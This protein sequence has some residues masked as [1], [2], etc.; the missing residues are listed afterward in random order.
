MTIDEVFREL[1]LSESAEGL[2][3]GWDL[4]QGCFPGLP[5][6]FLDE[7]YIRENAALVSLDARAID[8]LCQVAGQYARNEAM[9]RLLWHEHRVYT[10]SGD[11]GAPPAPPRRRR[12]RGGRDFVA[13]LDEEYQASGF[14]DLD[15]TIGDAAPGLNLLLALSALPNTRWFYQ[16]RHIPETILR[17]TL[18]DFAIWYSYYDRQLGYKGIDLGTLSWLRFHLRGQ[19]FR[20]GRLQFMQGEFSRDLSVYRSIRTGEVRALAAPGLPVDSRGLLAFDDRS[21]G[22]VWYTRRRTE[23]DSIIGN[24]VDPLGVI[25]SAEIQLDISEF[26]PVLEANSP[27]LEVH[28]PEGGSIRPEACEDSFN[29][30]LEF[31]SAYFPERPFRAFTC[32]SWFLGRDLL[33]LLPEA[34]NILRFSRE[35]FL[36]PSFGGHED[37]LARVFGPRYREKGLPSREH[38]TLLQQR[39]ADF[40]DSGGV[41]RHG[42]GFLLREDLPW[43]GNRYRT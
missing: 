33:D 30:A 40:V 25:R 38:A 19:L 7:S 14:P 21:V 13:F 28:I 20:L 2:S 3:R 37:I 6:F 34:S 36:Y 26:L 35:L 18:S 27:V 16:S 5:L 12:G 32:E 9:G 29:R 17:A 23:Q 42:G 4:S 8:Y 31:F 24:P 11:A 15:P 43:G 39:V 41:L 1:A 22:E 10:R